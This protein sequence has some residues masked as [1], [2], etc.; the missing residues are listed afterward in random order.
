M[1]GFSG[2]EG[3]IVMA[4]TNRPDVLDPALLRPGR[5]DRTITVNP[6]DLNVPSAILQVHARGFP[7]PDDV[8]LHQFAPVTPGITAAN[9]PTLVNQP[10]TAPPR[11]VPTPASPR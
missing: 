1:D 2:A 8:N 5:F 11:P 6:P 7:L 3:V 9:L 10:P 4:A